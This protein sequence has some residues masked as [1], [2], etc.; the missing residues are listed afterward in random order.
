[1]S[2]REVG[3][4]GSHGAGRSF[5][6]GDG[7]TNSRTSHAA[8]PSNGADIACPNRVATLPTAENDSRP[9]LC[10]KGV[11]HGTESSVLPAQAAP[12]HAAIS[13]TTFA[14]HFLNYL[15]P[16]SLRFDISFTPV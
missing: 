3:F 2:Q 11:S 4:A 15:F 7:G 14:F 5:A 9:R 12:A 6:D 13:P 1:M 10:H 8:E 16:G